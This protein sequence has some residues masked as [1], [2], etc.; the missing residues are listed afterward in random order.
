MTV[1][2][3]DRDKRD[4]NSYY[5]SYVDSK[6]FAKVKNYLHKF[7]SFWTDN[8]RQSLVTRINMT[9]CTLITVQHR[10]RKKERKGAVKLKIMFG[11][12]SVYHAS[13]ALIIRV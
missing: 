4:H 2:F 1:I 13:G 5:A 11:H 3:R 7:V 9:S 6:T 8:L 12:I 10:R